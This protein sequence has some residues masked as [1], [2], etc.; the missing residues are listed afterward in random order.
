MKTKKRYVGVL[1]ALCLV[2]G[3]IT[4]SKNNVIAS[5]QDKAIMAGI[6]GISV[7]MDCVYFG[8]YLQSSD[9]TVLGYVDEPIKWQT[10]SEENGKLLLVSDQ[11]LDMKQYYLILIS[12]HRLVLFFQVDI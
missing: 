6:S 7:Q 4:I 5:D 12:R 3:M 11:N 2:V 1:L 10:L 8:T 9:G